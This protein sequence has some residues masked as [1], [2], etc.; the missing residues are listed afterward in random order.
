MDVRILEVV[1]DDLTDEQREEVVEHAKAVFGG[2]LL[3]VDEL[4]VFPEGRGAT[5]GITSHSEGPTPH[6][7]DGVLVEKVDK[8]IPAEA[9]E[10]FNA[11]SPTGVGDN[12]NAKEAAW[13]VC[14]TLRS[15]G[16]P[17]EDIPHWVDIAEHLDPLTFGRLEVGDRFE[18]D[19][20]TYEKTGE[21][22][23]VL[24]GSIHGFDKDEEVNRVD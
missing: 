14:E 2:D 8:L 5:P 16:W 10:L 21:S 22:R 12:P 18:S 1:G 4:W 20:R 15:A 11:V 7:N 9:V 13:S 3:D 24:V 17:S 19:G 6:R 23:A